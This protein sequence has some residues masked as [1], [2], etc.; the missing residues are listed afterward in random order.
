MQSTPFA[1]AVDLIFVLAQFLR[2]VLL[3][4]RRRAG[5]MLRLRR[6]GLRTD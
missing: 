5:E 6:W 1:D 2:F 4:G 3:V